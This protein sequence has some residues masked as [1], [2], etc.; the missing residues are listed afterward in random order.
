MV[1]QGIIHKFEVNGTKIVLDVNSGAVHVVDDQAWDI[2]DDI[3]VL[4]PAQIVAK[5]EDKYSGAETEEVLAEITC[6]QQAGL[7]YSVDTFADTALAG[8]SEPA[9][10][11]LCLNVSHDC[12][13]RCRYCFAG[14]GHFGGERLLMP[15]ETG[16]QAIDFLI[17]KSGRRR[18]CE[19]DFFGGE[20]LMNFGTVR[21]L[22]AYGKARALET[23]KVIKFTLTTNALLLDE[24]ITGFLN[25]EGLSVV[26]SLD[27]RPE[28]NDA[29]RLTVSGG[30]GSYEHIRPKISSFIESR[31]NANYIVRGTY[32]RHNPD[33][34]LDV[35]HLADLGYRSVSVEPVVGAPADEWSLRQEDLEGLS[36]EYETLA[37]EYLRRITEGRP[38]EFFHFNLDLD[39]GPCLPKRL[40][41]CGAGYEYMAVTPEGDLYPCHQFVGRTQYRLGNVWDGAE[42]TETVKMFRN[43]HIY[44]KEDCRNCWARFHCG[45]GCHANA[46][47]VNGTILKPY[48]IGCEL[49]KKR[50]ESAM[51]IQ[52]AKAGFT[53][54]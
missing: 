18:H 30:R 50:L 35:L 12:N 36:K 17:K 31:N 32:T 26:L 22:V 24:E 6:L 37:V 11:S 39:H 14:S 34:A 21:E 8:E 29:M 42:N 10:K 46:E 40:S 9:V 53:E 20:P 7:L 47:L 51:Y 38:F 19:I 25:R 41:G 5:Y 48:H 49:E 2:I 4:S 16:R 23:G 44:A 27:G 33:F 45:G 52:A 13:L 3:P 1:K 43:A 15:V 28:V 54:D